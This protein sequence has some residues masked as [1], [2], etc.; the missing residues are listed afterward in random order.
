MQR[1]KTMYTNKIVSKA[2]CPVCEQIVFEIDYTTG[3]CQDCYNKIDWSLELVKQFLPDIQ[4]KDGN[5]TCLA[6]VRGREL[7]YAVVCWG[8]RFQYKAEVSWYTLVYCLNA[9]MFVTI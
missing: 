1:I 8:E 7:P 9:N 6:H 5:K 2:V 3:Y 4:V